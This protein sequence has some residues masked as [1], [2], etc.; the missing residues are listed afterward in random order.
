MMKI[1]HVIYKANDLNKSIELYRDMGYNVEYGSKYNPHNALIY[2]SDGP[3]IELLEK[4]PVSFFQKFVNLFKK[5]L[6][7]NFTIVFWVL[8]ATEKKTKINSIIYTPNRLFKL[9]FADKSCI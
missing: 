1:S 3:Y 6:N 2:F 4:S 8:I 5:K 9:H 7:D